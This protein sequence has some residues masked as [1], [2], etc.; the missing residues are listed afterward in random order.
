[1]PTVDPV[2][3]PIEP[4]V[5]AGKLKAAQK[6]LAAPLQAVVD[7]ARAA[8]ANPARA[9]GS[10]FGAIAGRTLSGGTSDIAKVAMALK[11]GVAGAVGAV[12][13]GVGGEM[14]SAVLGA[15]GKFNPAVVMQFEDALDDIQATLGKFLLPMVEHWTEAMRLAGDVLASILPSSQE[16]RA[17]MAEYKPLFSEIRTVMSAL[18]PIIKDAL[19][20]TMRL[21]ATEI[22][23]VVT[24]IKETIDW[25]RKN[26]P[27]METIFGKKGGEDTLSKRT[28][29]ARQ[30]SM[31][32][33]TDIG[34]SAT[35]GALNRGY[36]D[37]QNR[38]ADATEQTAKA[39]EALVE[40][41]GRSGGIVPGVVGVREA[42]QGAMTPVPDVSLQ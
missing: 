12:S 15:V 13:G 17:V 36:D 41:A 20:T 23:L 38:T 22:G 29:A 2:K 30:Y 11:G 6:K 3:V 4:T 16:L 14:Q 8:Y 42:V 28:L 37:A 26:V 32:S 21:W 27:N 5:D 31:V 40:I 1:M 18:A 34:R 24:V 25:L 19:V 10:A 9:A 7:T 33:A 35:L 39:A